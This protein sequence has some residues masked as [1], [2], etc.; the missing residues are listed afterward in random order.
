MN[1]SFCDE[2]KSR[3]LILNDINLGNRILYE[4]EHFV[5]FPSLGSF[6][7]GYLLIASKEHY[8]S[9][10]S[11]PKHLYQELEDVQNRVKKVLTK[12]YSLPLFYE[13]GPIIENKA[14]CCVDHAHTHALPVQ[15]D[16]VKLVNEEFSSKQIDTYADLN[17]IDYPYLFIEGN[18]DKKHIFKL[19]HLIPSQY[20]RQIIAEQ[21]GFPEKYDWETHPFVSNLLRTLETLK[22]K[23]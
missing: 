15:I 14:G 7:E 18:D 2:F 23:F 9:M 1:C 12:H 11:L 21:F 22:G 10:A 16:L 5:I 3:E 8:L 17:E 4:T 6:V 13:H 20:L 19:E